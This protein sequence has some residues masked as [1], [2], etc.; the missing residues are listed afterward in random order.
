MVQADA[1]AA[2]GASRISAPSTCATRRA[3]WSRCRRSRSA[4][5]VATDNA[6]HY[7]LFNTIQVNGNAAPGHSSGDAIRAIAEVAAEHASERL[8]LRWTG[9]TYQEIESGGYAGH[10]LRPR[11]RDGVP[12]AA[13]QYESWAL[14]FNVLLAV[15]FAVLG[16]LVALHL[17]GRRARHLRADRPRDARG[18]RGE[19]RDHDQRSSPPSGTTAANRCSTPR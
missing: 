12:A 17:T 2:H 19:E 1:A 4:L 18:T 14:P 15:A 11:A 13:A 8:H 3:A 16:A 5:G 6:T 7:N 9:T 10:H